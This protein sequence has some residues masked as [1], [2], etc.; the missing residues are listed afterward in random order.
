MSADLNGE[1]SSVTTNSSTT[2][3]HGATA[4]RTVHHDLSPF[5]PGKI[6][7]VIAWLPDP[8]PDCN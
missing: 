1:S 6:P 5:W 8:I 4:G 7:G 2:M 3:I